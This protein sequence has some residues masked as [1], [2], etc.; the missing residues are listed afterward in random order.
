M[1][2]WRIAE[3][4]EGAMAEAP[5]DRRRWLEQTCAGEPELLV[6]VLAL[7]DHDDEA[8]GFFERLGAGLEQHLATVAP[9]GHLQQAFGPYRTIAELGR[10]GMGVVYLAE[11]VDGAFDRRVALKVVKG[12]LESP[13]AARRFLAERQI[14]ARLDHPN[15]ARLFDGGVNAEGRP[16]LVMEV[17]DGLPLRTYCDRHRLSIGA[18]LK[19]FV[20]VCEAVELAHR[21]LVV[22][23][24]LKPSNILVTPDGLVKLVDFGIA[25]LLADSAEDGPEV[26]R[27]IALTPEYAAPEQVS[28]GP[29]TT[30][31]DVYSLGVVL[32]EL[33][34]GSRPFP[35]NHTTARQEPPVPPSAA[36]R[37]ASGLRPALD[38]VAAARGIGPRRLVRLL[39]GDLDQIVLEALQP[40]PARRYAGAQHL[41][42]DIE[43]H[44]AG[45][46]IV[47]RAASRWHR[48]VKFVQRHTL[49]V[50]L[51]TAALV[52]IL[53]FAALMTLQSWRLAREQARAAQVTEL[54]VELFEVADPAESRGQ[55]LTAREVLDRGT[56]RLAGRLDG[57]PELKSDLLGMM[58]R[59][60]RNLGLYDQAQS[61]LEETIALRRRAPGRRESIATGLDELAELSRLQGRY[62]VALSLLDEAHGLRP[63]GNSGTAVARHLDIRGKV[64]LAKGELDAAE[65]E[66]HRALEL[67]RAALPAVPA[68]VAENLNNLAAIAFGRGRLSEAE[69]RFR[70]ALRLRR[71]ALGGDHPLVAATLNNLATVLTQ[72]GRHGEAREVLEEALS[73]YLQLLGDHH[74]RVATTRNN[75]GLIHMALGREAE[76][77]GLFERSL[78]E[79]RRLFPSGHPD[80]A[81]SLTNLGLLLHDLG[82][83]EEAERALREATELQ[84]RIHGDSHP[85]VVA[86]RNNLALTLAAGGRLPESKAML[87]AG[88]ETLLQTLG[89]DHPQVATAQTN[90]ATVL[91]DS[92]ENARAAALL[93]RSLELRRTRLPEGHPHV[94]YSLLGLGRELTLDGDPAAAEPLLREALAIRRTALPPRHW[95]VAEAEASLGLC[96][97]AL[98]RGAEARL[99]LEPAASA[100]AGRPALARLAAAVDEALRAGQDGA[101]A[102]G[103]GQGW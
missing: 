14:L 93:A 52:L 100:L 97:I 25:K 70:E 83:L 77:L 66:V 10:G 34:A 29:V 95:R 98:G 16:F 60:Y 101:G 44:L 102:A 12:E 94:A 99:L 13:E 73:L 84:R 86:G 38:E 42:E 45:Y 6:E 54:L 96:L 31:T 3:V 43:R 76:A 82:R 30:A 36:I 53:A 1:N 67:N 91:A 47:A 69:S 18:R 74:P 56:A 79:R 27:S 26:D 72:A 41:R 71:S 4:L 59:V 19:L 90:L 2:L 85:A 21:N 48:C 89:P 39:E 81:Q 62:D 9:A 61:L 35:E 88:L 33:L 11:R 55:S 24:D 65:R 23:R 103:P 20:S 87:E 49:G 57:D 46:P 78:E 58:G 5:A 17:V 8:R 63:S 15:I 37:Q 75:L 51:A 80:V 50:S 64:L 68:A 28:G 40:D 22:H 32:F 7:L 92:G